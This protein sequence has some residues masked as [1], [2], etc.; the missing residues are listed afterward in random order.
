VNRNMLVLIYLS[1]LITSI[2]A[3]SWFDTTAITA[4]TNMGHDKAGNIVFVSSD[5]VIYPFTYLASILSLVGLTYYIMKAERSILYLVIAILA[6]RASTIGMINLYEHIYTLL[7]SLFAWGEN[8]WQRYYALDYITFMW[9][10]TGIL[11]ILSISPWW[12]RRNILPVAK[13][14]AIY[15]ALMMAW[16]ATGYKAPEAGDFVSYILN[17]ATRMIT[18]IALIASIKN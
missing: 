16:L 7:G 4:L 15:G 6:A 13:V 18:H 3:L 10:I 8:V 5:T 2:P 9:S 14:V 12:N 11:W 1:W 17:G